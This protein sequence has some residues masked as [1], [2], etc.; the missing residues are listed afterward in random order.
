MER[1]P[2]SQREPYAAVFAQRFEKVEPS[3]IREILKVAANPEIISF[4]GGLPNPHLFPVKAIEQACQDEAASRSRRAAI[5]H[6]RGL[7]P[8]CASSSPTAT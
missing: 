3:F 2:P 7:L 1:P 5:R 6:H 8:C 4:A